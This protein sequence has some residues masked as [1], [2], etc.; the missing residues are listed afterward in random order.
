M[1]RLLSAISEQLLTTRTSSLVLVLGTVWLT[2]L[3]GV[4]SL[5]L[6]DEGRYVGVAWQML[7][8]G[9]W[10]LPTL[11]G[12]PFF[13]K[14]PLFYWLTGLALQMFGANDWAARVA[15]ILGALIAAGALYLFVKHYAD[16]RLATLSVVVLVTQ[17]M[18]FAGAQYANLDMLVAGMITACIVCGASAVLRLDAGLPYRTALALTYLFAAL[19]VLAKGLIGFV[20]PGAILLAWILVRKRYRLIP[21]L[22]PI[23]MILLF[24][25]VAV[26]WFLWM[27]KSYSGF[28]DYFFVYHHF[29]RFA[30]TG[31]SNARPFWFYL[32]VVLLGTLPWS[33]WIAR[34]CSWKFL[35]APEKLD[36]RSLMLL[37]MLGILVFFSLPN[38]KLVG[39]IFPAL[40]PLACL[41]ADAMLAWLKQRQETGKPDAPVW[42]GGSLVVA[43][44]LCVAFIVVVALFDHT[45]TRSLSKQVAPLFRP[46]D[47]IVMIDE[48]EYDLP[49][50][51][52]AAK[53]SWVVTNWQDPEV[54]KEDNW[55]KELYDAARFDPVKQQEVLLL[56]GDLASRLCSWTGSGVLWIWGK[57]AQA[58]RYPFLPDSAIAFSERKKVVWRLDAEQ[59]Q[60]LDVCRGTPGRG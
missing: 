12:L 26:P 3:A 59:R 21:A 31:F 47:Q 9:N 20:L 36:I 13:H 4:R 39:Y 44:S 46:D 2:A 58:D 54:P 42:L 22:L 14:P 6:P 29:K 45:S 41:M 1:K 23:P 49:F 48:Y 57:T 15:S 8:S 24:L 7:N 55:R 35:V 30:E 5:M 60:Q 56:P 43:G 34:V 18:F 38:S 50:Y 25:T 37:W 10:L 19:G 16:K 40:P 33:L 52:R 51:L 17:P 11:D 32:P 27:Q 28:W 53:D